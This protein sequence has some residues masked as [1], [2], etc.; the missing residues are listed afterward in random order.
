PREFIRRMRAA[1]PAIDYPAAQA[2]AAGLL[3]LAALKSAGAL[4]QHRL[5]EAFSD[6]RTT[7]LY[8]DFAID[9]VTGRQVGHKM[10][11]VQ[12]HRG[13]KV[14]IEP[15]PRSTAPAIELPGIVTSIGRALRSLGEYGGHDER[16]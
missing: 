15:E 5:R 6:L 1:C 7:T 13:C 10:L 4:D 16:D 8:G 14:I 2:Y 9:R 12:W 11:L 3:T